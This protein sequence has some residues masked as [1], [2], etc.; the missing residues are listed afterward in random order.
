MT[1][2]I[3]LELERIERKAAGDVIEL[4]ALC[5]RDGTAEP[6]LSRQG[7]NLFSGYDVHEFLCKARPVSARGTGLMIRERKLSKIS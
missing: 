7:S 2:D 6:L 5:Q 4:G 1:Q 3:H